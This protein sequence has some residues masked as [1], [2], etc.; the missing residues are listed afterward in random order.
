MHRTQPHLRKIK[1]LLSQQ[2]Q[3]DRFPRYRGN[4][5]NTDVDRTPFEFEVDAAVLGKSPFRNIQMCHDFDAGNKRRL[6]Q[7]DSRR[8]GNI[9]QNPVD[10]VTNL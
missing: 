10:P 3:A 9:P 5:R 4:G 6:K 1:P 7:L 2:T 8:N